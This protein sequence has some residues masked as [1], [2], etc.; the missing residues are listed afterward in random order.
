MPRLSVKTAESLS[1]TVTVSPQT[2]QYLE[3]LVAE[4]THGG[5]PAEVARKLIN[6]GINKL[7]K[8]QLLAK[9]V[10]ATPE[11]GSIKQM[12]G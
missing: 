6:D 11:P 4:G 3:D 1:M 2:K 10:W 7:I 5:S 12:T 9:R 8:D